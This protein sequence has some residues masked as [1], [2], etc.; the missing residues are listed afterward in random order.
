MVRRRLSGEE[1][2]SRILDAAVERLRQEGPQG[3]KLTVL[4]KE[5]GVSHQAILHHFGSRDGLVRAVVRQALDSLSAELV[6]GMRT[7]DDHHRGTGVLLDRAF[8]V[9]GDQGYGRLLGWLALSE[10]EAEM[11]HT[12]ILLLAQVAHAIRERDVPGHDERDTLFTVILLSYAVLASSIFETG[13]FAAAGLANDP[14]A[15]HDFRAWLRKLIVEHLEAP[16]SEV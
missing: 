9:L 8:A 11:D 7:L 14:S 1:A 6:G 10:P 16:A 4:A 15:Q 5:L 2:R 12:P 3:L 13:T